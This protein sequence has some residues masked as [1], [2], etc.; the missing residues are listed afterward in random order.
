MITFECIILIDKHAMYKMQQAKRN[1]FQLVVDKQNMNFNLLWLSVIL[2][3]LI[4]EISMQVC[5]C[6]LYTYCFFINFIALFIT[7]YLLTLCSIISPL[8][9]STHY[10]LF[11]TVVFLENK[12]TFLVSTFLWMLK[13]FKVKRKLTKIHVAEL[14]IVHTVISQCS[15]CRECLTSQY[16]VCVCK[17]KFI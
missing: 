13:S 8:L 3:A 11:L 5:I 16:N 12:F 1:T 4:V 7:Y 10:S 9:I 2:C 15:I 6:Y 17:L 14:H